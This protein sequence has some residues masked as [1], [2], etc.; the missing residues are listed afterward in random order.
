MK[1]IL[2]AI[3]ILVFIFASVRIITSTY[4]NFYRETKAIDVSIEKHLNFAKI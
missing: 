3:L 2:I 4:E 1:K